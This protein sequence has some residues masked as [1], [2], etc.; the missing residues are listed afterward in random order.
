MLE[1]YTLDEK[2][3]EAA[4]WGTGMMKR[5]VV[6]KDLS[7]RTGFSKSYPGGEPAEQSTIW[8]HEFMYIRSGRGRYQERYYF[9]FFIIGITAFIMGV[10]VLILAFITDLSFKLG[11]FLTAMG[12]ICLIIGLVIREKWKKNC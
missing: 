10:I 9:G 12:S 11:L 8:I 3:F 1:K 7:F 2:D 5:F 6:A 4:A